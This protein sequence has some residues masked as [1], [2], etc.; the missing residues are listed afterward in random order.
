MGTLV[1]NDIDGLSPQTFT[2]FNTF[3]ENVL[4][5]WEMK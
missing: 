4:M 2:L 5:R 1:T 3:Q